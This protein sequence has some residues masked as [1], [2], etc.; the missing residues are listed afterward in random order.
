VKSSDLS[1]RSISGLWVVIETGGTTVTSDYS[2]LSFSANSGIQYTITVSS[3]GSYVF[4]HWSTGSTSPSITVT[5]S[6][7][8]TVIAYYRVSGSRHYH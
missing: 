6:Q 4:D 3:Y 7:A 8:M 5:P 1:G 2:P